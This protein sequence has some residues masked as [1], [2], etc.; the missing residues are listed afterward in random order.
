[1]FV[2][3]STIHHA[4]TKKQNVIKNNKH[5]ARTLSLGSYPTTDSSKAPAEVQ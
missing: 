4:T 3:T 2:K 1:M 5:Q